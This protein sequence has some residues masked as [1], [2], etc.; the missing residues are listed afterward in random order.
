M[1]PSKRKAANAAMKNRRHEV[2]L[3][4]RQ[5]TVEEQIQQQIDHLSEQSKRHMEYAIT[6]GRV[7]IQVQDKFKE[8]Q[9]NQAVALP[10]GFKQKKTLTPQLMELQSQIPASQAPSLPP[11]TLFQSSATQVSATNQLLVPS[12][13]S[14][15]MP[16]AYGHPAVDKT[17]L[18]A[19][20][21]RAR[22]PELFVPTFDGDYEFDFGTWKGAYLSK[23]SLGYIKTLAG[24]NQVLENRPG[25]L[26]ALFEQ[27]PQILFEI[28]QPFYLRYQ[29]QQEQT[30][31]MSSSSIIASSSSPPIFSSSPSRQFDLASSPLSYPTEVPMLGRLQETNACDEKLYMPRIA[32][33]RSV[34]TKAGP[35]TP[36]GNTR[37]RV[38]TK[39]L[40][41]DK[42]KAPYIKQEPLVSHR[43]IALR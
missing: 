9:Q 19:L 32:S 24:Q 21:R 26:K 35:S 17:E 34:L 20:E 36:A 4:V 27:K 37:A 22:R 15:W 25:F 40:R 3:H 1:P 28:N 7:K 23:L 10:T 12:S 41:K 18:T 29:R 2:A 31:L 38:K 5:A 13:V 14:A 6:L 8:T 30:G 39:V 33:P 16:R 43:I 11:T 42:G